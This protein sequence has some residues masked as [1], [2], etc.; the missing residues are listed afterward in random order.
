MLAVDVAA[1]CEGENIEYLESMD[2]LRTQQKRQYA[3]HEIESD[4]HQKD[5]KRRLR[6][7]DQ[8][9]P[10]QLSFWQLDELQTRRQFEIGWTPCEHV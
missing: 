6:P 4:L 5:A 8:Q 2:L 9:Q 1:A 10:Q 3:D 7:R